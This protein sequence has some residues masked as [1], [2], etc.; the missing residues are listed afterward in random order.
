MDI[1]RQI[2]QE[3]GT[4]YA[5]GS[6]IEKIDEVPLV[7]TCHD[8]EKGV[9]TTKEKIVWFFKKTVLPNIQVVPS[10]MPPIEPERFF[11]A[12]VDPQPDPRT[13]AT[14][15]YA[16]CLMNLPQEL[17]SDVVELIGQEQGGHCEEKR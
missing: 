13:G 14:K 4:A 10:G 1:Y 17:L 3:M 11:F 6:S 12:G 7:P 9:R 5:G 16:Y 15:A 2:F 8:W